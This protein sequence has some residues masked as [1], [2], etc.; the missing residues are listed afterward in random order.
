MPIVHLMCSLTRISDLSPLEGKALRYLTVCNTSISDLSA[1]RGM[2]LKTLYCYYTK[3]KDFTPLKDTPLKELWCDFDPKRDTEV[4]RSIKTLE[5]INGLPVA[6]F[7]KEVEAGKIPPPWSPTTDKAATAVDPAFIKEVAALPAEQQVARVVAKLK[8]LNPGYDGKEEHKI[9]NGQV[10]WLL[11]QN[12]TVRDVSPIRALGKLSWLNMGGMGRT[13]H[14]PLADL[15]PLQGLALNVFF[16]ENSDVS[17]LSPLQDMPLSHVYCG[18]TRV[19]DLTPLQGI[20]LRNLVIANNAVSDLSPLRGAP[21]GRLFCH[22]TTITDLSPL[23]DMPL[24]ELRC[25]F[26]PK[27][28]T[29]ILRSMKTLEQVNGLPVAEF[30]KQVEAGK[31][32]PPNTGL[33]GPSVSAVL[34][35]SFDITAFIKEV[36]ALPP[37]QQVA[38]V[39][40]KLK[41]LNP[42]YDGKEEHKIENG[43]VVDLTIW[44][45]TLKDVS[46]VR[47]LAK[48]KYLKCGGLYVEA[49]NR[50]E[51]SPLADLTPLQGFALEVLGIGH[52]EVT[53]LSPLRG[54]PLQILYCYG[55]KVTDLMPLQGMSLQWLD[56]RYTDVSDISPLRGIPLNKLLCFS[57]KVTDFSPIKDA[58]LKHLWCDFDPKRDTEILRSIKTLEQINGLPVA[59]FWKQ[60]EAG[61]IPP[62]NTGLGGPSVSAVLGKPFDITAFIKEVAALPAEQQV[63]RVVAKLKELNPGYDG[64][65]EHGIEN[66]QVTRLLLQNDTVK[67]ISPVRALAK[68]KVL[69]AGGGFGGAS[70]HS[71]LADLTPLQG[72]ELSSLWCENCEVNDLSPLRDMALKGLYCSFTQVSDLTPLKGTLLSSL[73]VNNSSVVDLQPLQGMPLEALNVSYTKVSILAPL[74]GAPLQSLH[75]SGTR[76]SDLSP[77]RGTRLFTLFC[78]GL[79]GNARASRDLSPLK[80]TP[81]KELRCDFDPN[82]DTEILRSIKTLE[83]VNGLPVAEFWKQVEAGKIPPPNTGLGGPSVSAVL[84]KPFDTDSFIKEVAA[85][86]AEQQVAR[87]VA[88]LKE[89]NPGYDGKE[90]HKIENGVVVELS[91][92]NT[93]I[94]HIW[95]VRAL[96]KLTLLFCGALRGGSSPLGDLAPLQGLPLAYLSCTN[97]EVADLSFLRGMPLTGMIWSG[98]NKLSDL[99]PLQGMR[100]NTLTINSTQISDLSPLR[101]MPLVQ[102]ACHGSKVTDLSFLKEMPLKDLRCDF[103][104]KRDTEILRSIKTLEKINGLP[105][106][107]FWKE[108]EAGKIPPP[109]TGL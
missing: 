88:K 41:E 82:R 24:T 53:D 99:A 4:L 58:P 106:A 75:M 51:R 18:F 55:T 15:T 13:T 100:L 5:T 96:D 56:V 29:D 49:T 57:T 34:G 40:A 108:V 19:S 42:G 23:K 63:A 60:V 102:L 47:A 37:E 8:E 64:K 92:Q 87:V 26:D 80:D 31:I 67:D 6:E 33:G 48:L 76:V 52:S 78:F 95:P 22:G 30:W 54:M 72:L 71:P 68:L 32:P 2:P 66:G 94:K 79:E 16:C 39:V 7:W 81:L 74:Q 90:T 35:K 105:V 11:L 97:S 77:L 65:E 20:P 70:T 44:N 50:S 38:R 45:S 103:D 36:A 12:D 43:Q 84:G 107:E 89:L 59:E 46:P 21:L 101:G 93:T 91:I 10:T 27:R 83:Q 14:S 62:P 109:N 3:V 69:K 61:K 73:V 98:S 25:D 104:P 86:P 9:E 1:L 17:D 85:L 28:D